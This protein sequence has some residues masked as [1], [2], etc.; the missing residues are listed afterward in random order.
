MLK[1][2]F[3]QTRKGRDLQGPVCTQLILQLRLELGFCALES[4]LPE[5]W[6]LLR[7]SH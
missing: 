1:S 4:D 2:G 3:E 6:Y 7:V 5:K